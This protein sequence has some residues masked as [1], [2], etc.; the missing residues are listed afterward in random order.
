MNTNLTEKNKEDILPEVSEKSRFFEKLKPLNHFVSSEILMPKEN[1]PIDIILDLTAQIIM[2]L[3]HKKEVIT[4]YDTHQFEYS[5]LNSTELGKVIGYYLN[6]SYALC[7]VNNFYITP[8]IK[9]H[10]NPQVKSTRQKIMRLE[11][12]FFQSILYS[13]RANHKIKWKFLNIAEDKNMFFVINNF[14]ST[15]NKFN[16]PKLKISK[17]ARTA[18]TS[19]SIEEPSFR[20]LLFYYIFDFC[21]HHKEDYINSFIT[22]NIAEE[23]VTLTKEESDEM[24]M[25]NEANKLSRNIDKI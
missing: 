12:G 14:I 20:N 2:V 23:E 8:L 11:R 17:N 16:Q 1:E 6:L 4:V 3:T 13:Q 19:D 25:D 9:R 5:L 10:A 15:H 21:L 7:P 22:D 18:S 24:I